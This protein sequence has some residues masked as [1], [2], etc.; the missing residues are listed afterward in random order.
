[1]TVGRVSRKCVRRASSE[2]TGVGSVSVTELMDLSDLLAAPPV[3]ML[4]LPPAILTAP[5]AV[6]VQRPTLEQIAERC[7]EIQA[8]WSDREERSRR[9]MANRW[10]LDELRCVDFRVS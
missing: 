7:A 3:V 5:S 1:M 9:P 10:T 8:G 4:P 2:S 6:V